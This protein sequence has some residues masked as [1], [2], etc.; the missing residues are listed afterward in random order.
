MVTTLKLIVC[1]YQNHYVVHYTPTPD[2]STC[3]EQDEPRMK[4]MESA[5]VKRDGILIKHISNLEVLDHGPYY[6]PD[7]VSS[8]ASASSRFVCVSGCVYFSCLS[9]SVSCVYQLI[10][11]PCF[12]SSFC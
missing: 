9:V 3:F 12:S 4:K 7:I 10:Y 1:D 8:L 5:P 2:P 11:L 6:T